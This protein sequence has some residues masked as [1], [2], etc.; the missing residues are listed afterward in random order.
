M[1]GEEIVLAMI[2]FLMAIGT[3]TFYARVMRKPAPDQQKPVKG[4]SP[5]PICGCGHHRSFH[6]ENGECHHWT[7]QGRVVERMCGCQKY[8]GPEPLPQYYAPEITGE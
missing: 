2:A 6:T 1:I 7:P 3:I 4:R 8:I 5:Q